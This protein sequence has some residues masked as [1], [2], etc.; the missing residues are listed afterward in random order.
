MK[1]C[2]RSF[3]SKDSS[4]MISNYLSEGISEAICYI[5][6]TAAEK[7]AMCSLFPLFFQAGFNEQ[8][9]QSSAGTKHG[10]NPKSVDRK[11]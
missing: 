2:F 11:C 4:T 5:L 3:D 9:I 1:C 8:V 6:M 7:A 10:Y